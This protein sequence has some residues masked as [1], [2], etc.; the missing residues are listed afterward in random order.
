MVMCL[1]NGNE[2][3]K[4]KAKNGSIC[5]PVWYSII[6]KD[7]KQTSEIISKMLRRFEKSKYHTA[8]QMLIFYDNMTKKE[9]Q[10]FR[11]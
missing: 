1:K 5:N 3:L 7:K 10:R 8:T 2:H 9:L 4:T 11:V 6:S